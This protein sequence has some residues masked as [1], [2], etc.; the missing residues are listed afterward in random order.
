MYPQHN[1]ESEFMES[2]QT[3]ALKFVCANFE[4]SWLLPTF[5]P[6]FN[7]PKSWFLK[8]PNAFTAAQSKASPSLPHLTIHKAPCQILSQ[9]VPDLAHSSAVEK[10][11]GFLVLTLS[12][13]YRSHHVTLWMKCYW[14]SKWHWSDGYFEE[15]CLAGLAATYVTGEFLFLTWPHCSQMTILGNSHKKH[16]RNPPHKLPPHLVHM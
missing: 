8:V 14:V 3:S 5:S 6:F 16:S 9:N 7:Y 10:Q 4:L 15:T 1:F 12:M 2:S 13:V 11:Y